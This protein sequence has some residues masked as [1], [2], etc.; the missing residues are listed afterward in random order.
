M[1]VLFIHGLFPTIYDPPA[2]WICPELPG[3]GANLTGTPATL[4][5]AVEFIRGLIREPAHIVGHSIGGAI[6]VLLAARYPE[7]VASLIN[8]EGNF[9][10]K[11]AFWSR[12]V[13]EMTEAEAVVQVSALR[14]DPA[15]WLAKADVPV[16][17]QS[18]AVAERSLAAL[19]RTIQ[20]MAR[21]VVAITAQP[22]YFDHV[23][24]VLDRGIPFH[25]IAGERSREGWDVPDFVLAR[26]ASMQIQPNAGHMLMM[27]DQRAFAVIV[28]RTIG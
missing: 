23:R 19:P 11:D 8:V 21:S 13:A 2:G 4:P 16:T 28:E 22:A 9:T 7:S 26:A 12:G 25:L 18:L 15:G 14:A 3:Y 10:L 1:P 5:N 20:S 24:S 27:N 17:P 6:A